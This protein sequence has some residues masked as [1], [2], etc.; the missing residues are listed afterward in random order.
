MNE[1]PLVSVNIL[2]Y[3]RKKELRNTL[4]KVYEQNYK[5]IE[6]IV[7]DN[8]ST[9]GT[10]EMILDEF[11]EVK[12]IQL[13]KNIGIAGWNKGFEIAKG[14]YILVLDDDAFP[15][16]NAIELSI[17]KFEEDNLIAAITFNL[18]DIQTNNFFNGTWLPKNKLKKVDWP[19]FIGCAFIVKIDR[20]PNSF[21][22]PH[23]YFLY[24]HEL[25][26]SAQI[27]IHGKKIMFYPEIFG[28]HNFKLKNKYNSFND[29]L[30]FQNTL[31]FILDYY[32]YLIYWLYYLQIIL[33]YFTR[34][35][36]HK[37]FR[38]YLSIVLSNF[39]FRLNH[40]INYKYFIFL[41][42]KNILNFSLISKLKLE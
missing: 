37:W 19:V 15:E 31:H 1:Q 42:S 20:L 28:Y 3:N 22:F 14:D 2:S 35:I 27:Y 40:K 29:A 32:P 16:N 12:F 9:D 39:P 21:I 24:Q 26:M 34:S 13:E 25:P 4:T 38:K 11:S 18:I 8:A 17:K 36:R 7:V 23:N 33:F 41:R 30:L 6:V 5:N 10:L